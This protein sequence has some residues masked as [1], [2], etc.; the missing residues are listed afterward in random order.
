MNTLSSAKYHSFKIKSSLDE[1]NGFEVFF[2]KN[3]SL[4]KFKKEKD[5]DKL[6]EQAF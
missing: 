4:E 1:S 2:I 6:F 5:F 3:E